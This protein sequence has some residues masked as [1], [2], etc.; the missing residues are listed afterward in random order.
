MTLNLRTHKKYEIRKKAKVIF[1]KTIQNSILYKKDIFI[2]RPTP[3]E[4]III[5]NSVG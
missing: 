3:K 1:I 5:L 2:M 4:V